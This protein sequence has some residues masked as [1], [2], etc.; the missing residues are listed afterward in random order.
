MR[1]IKTIKQITCKAQL[2]AVDFVDL[3]GNY[4]DCMN[5][6]SEKNIFVWPTFT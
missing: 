1:I 2:A 5:D 3:E 6:N 4:S